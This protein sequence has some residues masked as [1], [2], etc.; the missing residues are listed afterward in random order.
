MIVID[1]TQ[2]AYDSYQSNVCQGHV[3]Q[4]KIILMILYNNYSLK[5]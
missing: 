5:P 2:S 1:C 3:C 4:M